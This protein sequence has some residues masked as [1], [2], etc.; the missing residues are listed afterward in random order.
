MGSFKGANICEVVGLYIQS[1][2]WCY[3]TLPPHIFSIQ[4]KSG[5]CYIT[6]EWGH[7]QNKIKQ[8]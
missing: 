1:K 2:R 8:T 4:V 5:A 7:V 3:L 6:S